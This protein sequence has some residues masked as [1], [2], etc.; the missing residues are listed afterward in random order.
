ML[1]LIFCMKLL[2]VVTQRGNH[3]SFV[4]NTFIPRLIGKL[5]IVWG[6]KNPK[7]KM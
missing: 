3:E 7:R 2:S 1:Y 4:S 5:D 6:E